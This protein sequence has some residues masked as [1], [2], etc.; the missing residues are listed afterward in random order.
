[1]QKLRQKPGQALGKA[2]EDYAAAYL[3]KCGFSI[4]AR[5]FR[6]RHGELDIVAQKANQLVFVEVKTRSN[7]QFGKPEEG[8][9]PRKLAEV[10][11]TAMYYLLLHP[12]GNRQYRI[13]VIAIEMTESGHLQ[14]FNHLE[15]VTL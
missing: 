13:D 12:P 7:E 2:G 10:K 5:N 11:R 3:Q 4:I 14:Y 1:L 15:N 8:V 9:T 6:A